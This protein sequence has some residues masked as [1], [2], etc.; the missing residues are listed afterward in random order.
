MVDIVDTHNTR[1]GGDMGFE[2]DLEFGKEAEIKVLNR[3]Q[4][5]Y[6]MAFMVDGEH[7]AYDIFVPE[8][9]S[10]MEIKC[11]RQAENTK[12]IFIEIECNYSYSGILATTADWWIYLTTDRM[13]WT[14][15]ERIKRYIIS[16]AKDLTM[17]DNT[18]KGETSRVRG[19]FLPINHYE[20]I[21]YK[22]NYNVGK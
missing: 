22:V 14:K 6:P 18:P 5:K 3:I 17:F 21:S 11:D 19:Y 1:I 2:S 10:G 13:F 15:T 20:D 8:I 12:N 9:Q 4:K 16:E 7:K